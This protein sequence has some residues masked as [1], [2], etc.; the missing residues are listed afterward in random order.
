M[1]ASASPVHA[2][3]PGLARLPR[4]LPRD[5][6]R[7]P[8]TAAVRHR[9]RRRR[10]G[11]RRALAGRA[12]HERDHLLGRGADRRGAAAR[13][14]RAAGRDRAH[15]LRAGP[16]L[17]DV[18]RGHGA[19][20]EAA[21]PALAA[22]RSP[23]L[24]S[25]QVFAAAIRRFHVDDDRAAA[26]LH[27]LGL[28]RRAVGDLAGRVHRGLSSPATSFPSAWSLEFAVPLCFIA[29]VAPLFRSIAGGARPRSRR[30][31]R[32]SRSRTCRC[33]ST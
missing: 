27:F 11:G 9:L 33:G 19:V 21:A 20:L 12:R 24:L 13:R 32:C 17:P 4:R 2:P 31:S 25:D 26:A 22:A 18:Q 6:A 5:A 29:L 28:R 8:R 3:R 16:A 15:H 10:G 7:V 14:R 1:R 23:F 30:A